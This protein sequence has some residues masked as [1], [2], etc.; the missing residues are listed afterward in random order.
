MYGES[1]CLKFT[2]KTFF[3]IRKGAKNIPKEGV[4]KK[5]GEGPTTSTKNG[6]SVD[7]L[8]KFFGGGGRVNFALFWGECG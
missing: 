3:I 7:E 5:W 8:G 4:P 2:K 1:L 6:G